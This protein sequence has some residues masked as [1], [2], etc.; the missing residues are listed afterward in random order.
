MI[1]NVGDHEAGKIEGLGLAHGFESSVEV[2]FAFPKLSKAELFDLA[3][4]ELPAV[5][6]ELL[7]VAFDGVGSHA[8]LEHGAGSEEVANELRHVHTRDLREPLQ[9]LAVGVGC[10]GGGEVKSVADQASTEAN[11]G[12]LVRCHASHAEHQRHDGAGT[13]HGLVDETDGLFGAQIATEAMVIDDLN[14]LCFVRAGDSL[15]EFI[16]VHQYKPGAGHIDEVGLGENA[17]QLAGFFLYDREQRLVRMLYLVLQ[18]RQRGA[19]GE[20]LETGGQC[21]ANGAGKA[22]ELR[23]TGRVVGGHDDGDACPRGGDHELIGGLES[24]GDD[25]A[26]SAGL[27]GEIMDVRPISRHNRQLVG[28]EL[29]G[30]FA[31]GFEAG[32]RYHEKEILEDFGVQRGTKHLA[33]ERCGHVLEAGAHL[34]V[35]CVERM[36]L[37]GRQEQLRQILNGRNAQEVPLG[38]DHRQSAHFVLQHLA[39]DG[40]KCLVGSHR[41]DIASANG[42]GSGPHVHDQS[43]SGQAGLL[44]YP[45]S[46]YRQLTTA[47]RLR[48][49]ITGG[50]QERGISN[51]GTNGVRVR[52]A[53]AD[54]EGRR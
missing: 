38:I 14:D 47:S 54:D 28:R 42:G 8:I 48:R 43:G 44:E 24:A 17:S 19:G 18:F 39:V 29:L 22:D 32:G 2:L 21:L 46:A 25:E 53:M 1:R 9:D 40:E 13:A 20:T 35:G 15:G 50:A 4:T 49:R 6:L 33:P 7:A 41:E 3:D 16:V 11:G 5:F 34:A 52:I 36:S 26:A 51:G 23:G 12:G 30:A 31:S 45:G 37:V 10:G 27:N